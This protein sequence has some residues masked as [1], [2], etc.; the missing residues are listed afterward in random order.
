[1]AATSAQSFEKPAPKGAVKLVDADN[2]DEL[3]NLL[4]NE[5]KVI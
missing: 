5:A 3:I 4:H 1:M 2:V